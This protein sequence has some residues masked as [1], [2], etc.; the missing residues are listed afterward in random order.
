M[1]CPIA[2]GQ[3]RSLFEDLKDRVALRLA[4]VRQFESGNVLLT[5]RT[6]PRD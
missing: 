1:V 6:S 3:G 5:Y 4:H 2:I